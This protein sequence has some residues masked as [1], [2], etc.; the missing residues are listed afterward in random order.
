MN[1]EKVWK[2]PSGEKNA[3]TDLEGIKVGHL[4]VSKDILN[5]KGEKASIR[6]GLTAVL[7]YP[8]EKEM[9]LFMGSFNL[10]GKNEMTGYEVAGDFCYLNSPIVLTNSF[11]VGKAYNAVLSYGFS[12]GRVEIWPPLVIGIDDSFLNDSTDSLLDEENILNTFQ[13]A[14]QDAVEQGSVGIGF[15]LRAYGYKGGIGTASRK[16]NLAGQNFICGVLVA[17]NHNN[18]L[19]PV[20]AARDTNFQTNEQGSFTLVVG[21]DIPLVPYQIKTIIKSLVFKLSP[22]LQTVKSSD[23]ITC[24]IFTTANP[25]VMGEKSSPI[26]DFRMIGDSHLEQIARAAKEATVEATV[27]SLLMASPLQGKDGRGCQTIP[28]EKMETL[29]KN[30]VR[31]PGHPF[32]SQST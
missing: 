4:T 6:T 16:I 13:M 7:P 26:H 12:L 15:G 20:S 24:I 14:S 31:R 18:P 2:F 28:E 5:P 22:I 27:N 25:M 10:W 19:S 29:I 8:M 17:S 23:D 9:R 30:I 21:V 1:S 3:I 11:N 32:P